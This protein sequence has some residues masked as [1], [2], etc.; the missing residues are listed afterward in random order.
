MFKG[1]QN[2]IEELRFLI[3]NMLDQ[4]TSKAEPQAKHVRVE[5]DV[6]APNTRI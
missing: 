3:R 2:I 1:T 4:F 6:R 5:A